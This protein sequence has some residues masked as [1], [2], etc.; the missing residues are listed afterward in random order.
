MITLNLW[1]TA[2]P[3]QKLKYLRSY[4]RQCFLSSDQE[5]RLIDAPIV[6]N[7]FFHEAHKIASVR[8]HYSAR[9]IIEVL[10]HNS[11]LE[12]GDKSFK[13]N[14]HIIPILA[15]ISMEMFPFLNNLFETRS[16]IAVDDAAK[17]Y[18]NRK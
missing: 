1:I 3:E 4:S 6:V 2:S 5:K 13:I 11:A 18:A 10:R 15:R 12:D 9:I 17:Q 16:P 14:D 8:S 7:R